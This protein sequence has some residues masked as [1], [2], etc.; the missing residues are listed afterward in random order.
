MP[1]VSGSF[2]DRASRVFVQDGDVFRTLS[3]QGA[4]D[5]DAAMQGR[6]L[7]EAIACGRVIGTQPVDRSLWPAGLPD[8]VQQVLSHERVPFISYP[9]EWSFGMLRDAALLHLELLEAAVAEQCVLKDASPYNVQFCGA[10][11]VFIDVGS[12]QPLAPGEPWRA[13]RQF[14]ELFLFPLFLQAFGRLDFQTLLRSELE[15]ISAAR[16]LRLLSW[17]DRFRSG[18][19]SHVWLHARLAAS[20]DRNPRRSTVTDLKASGF[21]SELIRAN[22]RGLSRIVRKL[23][24][25]PPASEWTGYDDNSPMVARDSEAKSQF[26]RTAA[27]RSEWALAWDLGC[28]R[29]RYA[30]LVAEFARYV[31]AMDGD[32][33]C[34]ESV[35]RELQ[36]EGNQRVLPLV[37]NLANPSP[38]QGWRGTE[39]LRLEERGRPEFVLCLGL[40]HHLVIAAN[41]PLSEVLDWLRELNSVLVI[42]FP[43]RRDPMVQAL[44]RNKVDQYDDYTLENF[45]RELSDRF[46]VRRR[47]VLPSGERILF[48]ATPRGA[49]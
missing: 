1:F 24:W 42:E 45:E 2:R 31:V 47:E 3:Q 14:C 29:A 39:R 7:K 48:E 36:A 28:N 20:A 37:V 35:Y 23:N 6:F 17:R 18:V 26:V 5:F 4:G 15:G 8:S 34:I 33:G 38:A 13:Y 30:R 16:C 44:L 25:T 49:L 46:E 43:T 10:R 12:F 40:I 32:H 21:N 19:F 27:A 9:Y 22:L 11:P 41:V